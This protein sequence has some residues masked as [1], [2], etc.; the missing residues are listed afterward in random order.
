MNGGGQ[1]LVT[2]WIRTWETGGFEDQ[3]WVLP[4]KV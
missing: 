3:P 2:D 4:D 1:V